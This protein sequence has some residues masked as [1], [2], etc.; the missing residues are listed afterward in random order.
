[1]ETTEN[2][3]LIYQL[4]RLSSGHPTIYPKNPHLDCGHSFNIWVKRANKKGYVDLVSED[5]NNRVYQLNEKGYN[6]LKEYPEFHL[7]NPKKKYSKYT[8]K[9]E[10]DTLDPVKERRKERRRLRKLK[11]EGK[12]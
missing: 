12:L 8:I 10:E 3:K 11:K 6:I 7:Q 4:S 9:L 2:R 5:T 1:M